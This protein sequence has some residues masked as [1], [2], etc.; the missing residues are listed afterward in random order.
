VI[1]WQTIVAEH[2]PAVWRTVYRLVSHRE[3]ALDCYQETFFQAAQYAK[4]HVVSNWPGLLKQ[5]A[6][7]RALDCLRQRYRKSS[8][9][10]PLEAAANTTAVG[11]TPEVQAE[12]R[13]DIER[14]RQ[15]L[16]ELSPRQSEVFCLREIELMSTAEVADVLDLSPDDVA[17]A[18]H[19][20]KRKL[21]EA[22]AEDDHRTEVHR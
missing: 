6:S 18:L 2:G 13:E 11:P 4:A 8:K 9:L 15:A 22:L 19:R 7:S 14:L 17:T 10:A 16:P 3:D 21:R 20:A 5:M 12:L 1:D